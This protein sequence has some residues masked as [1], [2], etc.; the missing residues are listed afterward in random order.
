MS[1]FRTIVENILTEYQSTEFGI[2]DPVKIKNTNKIGKITKKLGENKLGRVIYLMGKPRIE[3]VEYIDFNYEKA[4]E[5]KV[6]WDNLQVPADY[7]ERISQKELDDYILQ[8]KME[9]K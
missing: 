4:K 1:K 7:L 2:D 8:L 3:N 6:V 9:S 5:Q